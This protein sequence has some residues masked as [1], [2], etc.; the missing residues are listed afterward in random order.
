M[1]ISACALL[2]LVTSTRLISGFWT[3]FCQF[4]SEFFQPQRFLNASS[5][6]WF[7]PT[8]VCIT[9][10]IGGLKNLSTFRNA[11]LCARPMNLSPIKQIFAAAFLAMFSSLGIFGFGLKVYP[12]AFSLQLAL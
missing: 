5:S 6:S 3:A 11:L 9:G 7:R 4:V 10:R 1:A 8:T 2:G 12:G